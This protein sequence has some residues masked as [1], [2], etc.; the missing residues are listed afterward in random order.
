MFNY[1]MTWHGKNTK[2]S[3]FRIQ[4]IIKN[5][6][7]FTVFDPKIFAYFRVRLGRRVTHD[8]PRPSGC[9]VGTVKS[10]VDTVLFLDRQT[11]KGT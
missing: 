10:T 1:C 11:I 3:I 8:D 4:V 5:E 7:Y 2:Y 9:F 6:A